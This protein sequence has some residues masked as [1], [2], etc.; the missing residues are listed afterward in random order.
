[1]AD[2]S[3][4]VCAATELVDGGKGVRFNLPWGRK[5]LPAFAIRFQGKVH[6]YLNLCPHQGT[7]LDWV[8]GQ[9]FDDS[10]LYLLCATHGAAFMP[11]SGYCCAGPCKG[12]KL[13]R[14]EVEERD[15][16]IHWMV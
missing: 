4:V 1:M 3:G 10:Q 6:A 15:G 8:E 9:F 12:Q 14:V 11:A 5:A 2:E 13:V 7:E 16:E